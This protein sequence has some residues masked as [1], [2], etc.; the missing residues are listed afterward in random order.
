MGLKGQF[1]W[2]ESLRLGGRKAISF[3]L[4][5]DNLLRGETF[6]CAIVD[7]RGQTEPQVRRGLELGPR[8]EFRFDY[9]SCGW[10]WCAGDYLAILGK[11]DGVKERWVCNP[12][13]Y[14][15]GECPQC[16]GT[17]RCPQCGGTGTI[18]DRRTH[19][20]SACMACRGTG[21]CQECYV[22]V[23]Q[24]SLGWSA[25]GGGRGP[26]A[27]GARRSQIAELQRFIDDLQRKIENEE[28]ALRMMQLKDTDLSSQSAY[29][30]RL[31][32]KS[33]YERDLITAQYKLQQLEHLI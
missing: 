27:A 5:C 9:D 32:L 14:G 6:D 13:I 15:R 24:G 20:I 19:T 12:R 2:Y 23:R 26:D 10:D 28:F 25:A 3:V 17:L 22:P 4:R 7:G 18:T 31:S 21:V 16:H 33:Q 8:Q 1:N 30:A 11:N 29:M